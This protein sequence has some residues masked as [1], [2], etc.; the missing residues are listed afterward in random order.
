M[1]CL[2]NLVKDVLGRLPRS[3]IKCCPTALRRHIGMIWVMSIEKGFAR[4]GDKMN[5]R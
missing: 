4:H 2:R 5:Q 3:V 1:G